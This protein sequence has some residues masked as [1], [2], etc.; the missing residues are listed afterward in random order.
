[1]HTALKDARVEH[2]LLYGDS[3]PAPE[4]T[5]TIRLRNRFGHIQADRTALHAIYQPP[6]WAT[7]YVSSTDAEFLVDMVAAH[8]PRTV[9]ELGVAAGASS[10]ALLYALDQLSDPEARRL[11]SCDVRPTC[12]FNEAYETGQACREMY[13]EPRARWHRE[14]AMDAP[15]LRRLLAAASVDLTFVDANHS[16]PWPLLDLLHV[17]AFAKPG[18]WVVLH[19]VDLP[20]QHP[21]HQV[22]GPRWLFHAWPF[23][24]VKG[25][26]RWVSIAA[27][28]LPDDP[29][30]LVPVA[31]SLMAKPWEQA[32]SPRQAEL[33][34]VFATVRA[35]LEAQLDPAR[36]GYAAI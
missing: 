34:S 19:D 5:A 27:V 33:P 1:M 28:Q 12:Y 4:A 11:Y 35:A 13:P 29:A 9:V 22:F 8:Q 32:P 25:V 36:S 10:A 24:K 7:G 14:F 6:A 20:I 18:S 26:G 2:V 31:L 17:T 21:E 15:G 16:H 3:P 23:N 30:L